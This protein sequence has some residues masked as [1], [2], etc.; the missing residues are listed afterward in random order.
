MGSGD[1]QKGK[2]DWSGDLKAVNLCVSIVWNG[3]IFSES[4]GLTSAS[5]FLL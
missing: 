1:A 3:Y 2:W 5:A 4:Q